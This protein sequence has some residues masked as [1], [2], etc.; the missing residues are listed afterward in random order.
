MKFRPRKSGNKYNA[1]RTELKGQHFDSKFEGKVGVDLL[2]RKQSGEK[3]DIRRQVDFP[4]VVNG[5]K[6]CTY[7]ADFVLDHEDGRQEVV[8]AKGFAQDT[9]RIKRN[10]MAALYP[11]VKLTVETQN[12]GWRPR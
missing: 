7:R 6:I 5:V 12:R 2:Y 1:A 9:W 10:L 3:F 4:F 8:E 11:E